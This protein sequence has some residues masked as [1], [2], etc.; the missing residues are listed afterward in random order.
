M[1]IE[2]ATVSGFEIRQNQNSGRD[3]VMLKIYISDETDTYSAQLFCGVGNNYIPPIDSSVLII[4]INENFKIAIASDDGLDPLDSEE[5]EKVIYSS[6]DDGVRRAQITLAQEG[7]LELDS[8][9]ND[10]VV[11]SSI[12]LDNNGDITL[13]S[14]TDWAIQFTALKSAFDQLVSDFNSLVSVFNSHQHNYAPGP[15]AP[16]PTVP[17]VPPTPGSST[18]ADMSSSKIESIKVP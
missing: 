8:I 1:K 13:N 6:D 15:G 7:N 5:G 12:L 14:G 18:T 17:T 3:V 16:V 10:E 9:D 11:Q 2:L 4:S